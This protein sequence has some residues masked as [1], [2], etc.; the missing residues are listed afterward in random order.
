MNKSFS[1]KHPYI[2]VILLGL[3]CTFMTAFGTAL[4]QIM[5]LDTNGQLIVITIFIMISVV[6]GLIIMIRSRFR[7]TEYGFRSIKEDSNKKVLWYIPLVV[8]EILPIVIS[9]FAT[10][11]TLSQYIIL[12]FLMIAVGFNEEIYFRGLTLKYMGTKSRKNAIIWSSVVFGILHLA[13]AL[14]GK[15]IIY[16]ILQMIFSFLVGF[17][18]AE[19]VCITKSIWIAIF[20]HA[21]HNYIASITEGNMDNKALIKVGFQVFVLFVY[22]ILMWRKSVEED[23]FSL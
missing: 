1:Q 13:N 21:A 18:L 14:N 7:L 20:W 3:F 12:I 5:S 10:D 19:I 9:G 11:V 23:V 6:I 22:A 15:N 17:V 16:L 4:G 8:V 2:F